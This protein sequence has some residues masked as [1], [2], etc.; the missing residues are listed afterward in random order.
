MGA[1]QLVQGEF[2]KPGCMFAVHLWYSL[3]GFNSHRSLMGRWEGRD[4]SQGGQRRQGLPLGCPL[5]WRVMRQDPWGEPPGLQEAGHSWCPGFAVQ[6]AGTALLDKAWY[7]GGKVSWRLVEGRYSSEKSFSGCC[8]LFFF[9][10]CR[11]LRKL[12]LAILFLFCW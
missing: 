6:P 8:E 2:T 1:F 3:T 12:F 4:S 9:L 11:I 5:G 10:T 7:T